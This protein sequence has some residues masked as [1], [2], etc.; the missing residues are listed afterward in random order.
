MGLAHLCPQNHKP[1]L[2]A[3]APRARV[4]VRPEPAT[5]RRAACWRCMCRGTYVNAIKDLITL[6]GRGHR[7][8]SQASGGSHSSLATHFFAGPAG[9]AAVAYR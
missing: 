3:G 1:L 8:E 6:Q 7:Q 4:A 5:S 9:E 2:Q